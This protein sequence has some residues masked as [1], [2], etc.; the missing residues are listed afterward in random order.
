MNGKK[1]KT[2]LKYFSIMNGMKTENLSI[3]SYET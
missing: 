1:G 2:G 3:K